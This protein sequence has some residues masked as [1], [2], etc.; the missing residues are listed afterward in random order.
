MSLEQLSEAINLIFA[1]MAR[2]QVS[3][4]YFASDG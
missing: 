2:S 4:D 3:R 1:G